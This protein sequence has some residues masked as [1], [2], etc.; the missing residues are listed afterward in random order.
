MCVGGRMGVG[1]L[2]PRNQSG[3]LDTIELIINYLGDE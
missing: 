1:S 3:S 2:W